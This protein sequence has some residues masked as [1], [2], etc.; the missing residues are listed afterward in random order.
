MLELSE[1]TLYIVTIWLLLLIIIG[2]GFLIYKLIS[3]LKRKKSV[4]G[5]N[6]KRYYLILYLISI[7]LT[8]RT[9]YFPVKVETKAEMYSMKFGYPIPFV[10]QDLSGLD[11]PLPR[12]VSIGS[13]WEHPTQINTINFIFSICIFFLILLFYSLIMMRLINVYKKNGN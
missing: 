10:R 2:I 7:F 5:F 4:L 8:F 13:M 11:P 6:K 9:A 12:E 3:S 1:F